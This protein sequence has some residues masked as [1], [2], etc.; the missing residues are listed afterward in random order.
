MRL[1]SAMALTTRTAAL[2]AEMQALKAEYE[3]RIRLLAREEFPVGAVVEWEELFGPRKVPIRLRG[4]V[5]HIGWSADVVTAPGG[6]VRTVQLH[7]L[8]PV[9]A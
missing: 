9:N 4:K 2:H 6:P 3:Q 7:Q 5:R 1:G 8:V